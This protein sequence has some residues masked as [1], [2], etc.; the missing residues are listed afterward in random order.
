M[1]ERAIATRRWAVPLLTVLARRS[2]EIIALL[3]ER[4][5]RQLHEAARLLSSMSYRNVLNR[6]YAVVRDASDT[7]VDRAASI[8]AGDAISLE[9]ADGRIAQRPLSDSRTSPSGKADTTRRADI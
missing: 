9:F 6:G 5:Q 7:A 3:S 1:I 4:R 2:R 8:A